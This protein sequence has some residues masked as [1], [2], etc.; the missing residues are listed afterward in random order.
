MAGPK[1]NCWQY[2]R[3]GREPGGGKAASQGVC[4]AAV[5]RS[6][7]GINSGS[8]AG[9]FCWAVTGT[10]CG[11]R[12]QGTFAQKRA[13]CLE[14]PFYQRVQFEE[15]SAN[16][17]TKFLRFITPGG[18]LLRG[19]AF[20]RIARG[21]RLIRQGAPA[22]HAFIIQRGACIELVEREGA[23]YPIAQRGEGDVVG[24]LT[25]LTGE[26]ETAHVEAESDLEVWA[27]D[28]AALADMTRREP[29]LYAFLT[30]LAAERFDS[31]RPTAER[32]IGPYLAQ[33][34]IGR[35][36][37]SLVYR[38]VDTRSG[39]KVA[40]KMLRHHLALQPD[41]L[42]GFRREAEII[43]GLRHPNIPRVY[44]TF[45]RFRTLFI[46]MELLEGRALRE[47][48]ARQGR[49]AP[50]AALDFLRQAAA[51][52]A[53][54]ARAGLIHRD[55][56]PGNMVVGR[57]GT[58]K[59][60]DF[61]L[62]CPPGEEG[63]AEE[64]ALAYRAP[65][66]LEGEPAG[67]MSDIYALGI[68]AFELVTGTTPHAEADARSFFER[69][70][71]E[72]VPDPGGMLP[73]LPE[74]LREFIR[75][76]CRR[77]PAGRFRDA[78]AAL[79]ALEAAAARAGPPPA[80]ARP[81]A[82]R[83]ATA[84]VTAEVRS[85]VGRVRPTNQDRFFL[86]GR[87][88]GAVMLAVA[89]G[90]GGEPFG[91]EAAEMVVA[92]L[93]EVAALAPG[94]AERGLAAAAVR[95]DRRIAAAARSGPERGGMGSTLVL[96][97]LRPG[98]ACWVHVG[99]SRLY[100][101]RRGV[102]SQVTQDQTLA[103]F[104]L[105]EGALTAAQAAAGHYSC[106]IPDQYL[107]CGYCEPESGSFGLLPGDLL[108]FATDGLHRSVAAERLA[109]ILGAPGGA[110]GKAEALVAAALA[111]GGE[112]NI[113]ALVAQAGEAAAAGAIEGGAP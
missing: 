84:L 104:L 113:T 88:D 108:L 23:L 110:G 107:G 44:D 77:D 33:E 19:L 40:I 50:P 6:F 85:H 71:R 63:V 14:C 17:R 46:V 76:A 94:D 18:F 74:G 58:L 4:P 38:G 61:G 15:G 66:L 100:L 47:I 53:H 95:L 78:A 111:A 86:A 32:A 56:H 91:E 8:C 10:L 67:A 83:L 35:G 11:G 42:A 45:E 22:S 39:R 55:V 59:L 102:F 3:C 31:R 12:R 9:R 16:L 101:W 105:A 106:L 99:D 5:D 64:G 87:A 51:A 82:R 68:T 28:P 93:A 96:A 112:D 7:E 26:P 30:E 48:L 80:A 109:E 90:L 103:R 52:L 21:T 73:G 49:L 92:G 60:I 62:A 81:V 69:R 34:I 37:Y 41:F 98:R 29:E 65:E 27:V 2:M 79:A 54:A 70:R 13:S 89:D 20:R 36:G 43:A 1:I 25:L 75:I 57:D 72:E 97:C 24:I